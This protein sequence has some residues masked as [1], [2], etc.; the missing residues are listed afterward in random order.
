MSNEKKRTG[1]IAIPY[2]I[3]IF[4]G[5]CIVGGTVFGLYK[6]FGIGEEEAPP[7]PQPRNGIVTA[8]YE[9]SHTI[10]FIL[11]EPET[12]CK[13]TFVLMRSIPRDKKMLFIG[14][15]SNTVALIDDS[16]QSLSGTY[17]R[18]GS[19]AARQFVQSALGVT[20]D[21]YMTFDSE[22]FKKVCDIFGG[23][24]YGVDVDIV[25]LQKGVTEQY[26]NSSQIEKFVTYPLFADGEFGRSFRVASL[27][28][29]MINQTDTKRIAD[30]FDM[31]FETI[32]NMVKTDITSVDYGNRKNAIKYMFS[33]GSSMGISI[34]IDG[35]VSGNDFVP[36]SSFISNL[37]EEYFAED[38]ED[39]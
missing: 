20:V 38:R 2:L 32:I 16:Q 39:D 19:E 1:R 18:G 14:I 23:V 34:V 10:L 28:S 33:Y 12:D 8:S 37:P 6:Y 7:K 9:D 31:N 35:T 24:S 21:R 26:L 13:S 5:L 17:E 30:S 27:I 4:V 15:P 36:S 11:D 3:T 29:N 22:A 25:G